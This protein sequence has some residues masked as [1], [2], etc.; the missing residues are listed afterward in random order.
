M[1]SLK[2]QADFK[3]CPNGFLNIFG[4]SLLRHTFYMNHDHGFCLP[5]VKNKRCFANRSFSN[6]VR[7]KEQG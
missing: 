3:I 5:N 6:C 7:T 2:C 4:I 1:V